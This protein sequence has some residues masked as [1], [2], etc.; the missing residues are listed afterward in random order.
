MGDSVTFYFVSCYSM[1]WVRYDGTVS[2]AAA[3]AVA[4]AEITPLIICLL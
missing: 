4:Y 2:A 3:T 1:L